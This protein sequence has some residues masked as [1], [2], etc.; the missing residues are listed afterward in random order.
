MAAAD[1]F[2]FFLE[3]TLKL[4]RRDE[5]D[6]HGGKPFNPSPIDYI[7]RNENKR[8]QPKKIIQTPKYPAGGKLN[9]R[10]SS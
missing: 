6:G 7:H 1:F 4:A 3:R 8:V 2:S 10:P 9:S 5:Q